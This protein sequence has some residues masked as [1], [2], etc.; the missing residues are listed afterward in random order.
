[1][2]SRVTVRQV[3][4]EN[5][6]GE[7]IECVICTAHVY[8]TPNTQSGGANDGRESGGGIN[9]I[10]LRRYRDTDNC[11]CRRVKHPSIVRCV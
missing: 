10:Q 5:L 9:L 11:E 4:S 6:A 7:I 1:M 3:E 2:T 8:D